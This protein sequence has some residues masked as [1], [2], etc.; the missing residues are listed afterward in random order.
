[1]HTTRLKSSY[2]LSPFSLKMCSPRSLLEKSLEITLISTKII[3]ISF[4]TKSSFTPL[5]N[6][7]YRSFSISIIAQQLRVRSS[8]LVL[9]HFY[10]N[11]WLIVT[12]KN[13]SKL[14]TRKCR[15]WR[16]RERLSLRT[17]KVIITI[18]SSLFW[19]ALLF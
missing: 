13:T 17:L 15:R 8:F 6:P 12:S 3:S 1:M 11:F 2:W 18:T 9:C 10:S 5:L 16:K 14:R 7:T 19:T 4:C